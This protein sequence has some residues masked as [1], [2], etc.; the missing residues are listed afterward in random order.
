MSTA[1]TMHHGFSA[2]VAFGDLRFG[3]HF[4]SR[5]RDS[6]R[7]A[8][9]IDIGSEHIDRERAAPIADRSIDNL[10][11]APRAT[12]PVST[13]AIEPVR[14]PMFSYAPSIVAQGSVSLV[15]AD[16]LVGN[17]LDAVA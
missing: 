12:A 11:S 5:D 13:A 1:I 4:G 7:A 10:P 17:I 15:R 6:R 14:R 2:L 9:I 16:T 3:L 8:K